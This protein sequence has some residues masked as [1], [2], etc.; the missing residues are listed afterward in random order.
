M[1]VAA[2][3][4]MMSGDA[5]PSRPALTTYSEDEQ[6]LI[7]N[8]AAFGREVLAPKVM[9]MD[10][11]S[12]LD[13]EVLKQLFANGLMGIEI[14]AEY[15]G[16]GMTFTQSCL[17]I[18]EIAKVDPAVAVCVDIQNTLN[19]TIIRKYGSEELKKTWLPKLATD[20]LA[21]F[22]LSEAG[23]GSDAFAMKTTAT[24]KGDNYVINGT[25]MWISNS[26]EAGVFVVFANADPK[27]GYKGITAF[28][29]PRDTKGLVIG[30]K[31]DKLGIRASSTCEVT[32]NDVEV[33]AT[34]VLG[35]V[36]IGYKIAIESL[37][38][39]RIGIAAQMLGLAQGAFNNALPYI[40]QRKQFGQPLANFQGMQ[41]Q[42]ADAATSIESARLLVLN[43][44]RLKDSGQPFMKQ[45]AMAKLVAS[46]VAEDVASN[47]IEWMGGNGF[48]RGFAE[49][50]L[51][52]SKIGSIYEGTSN[53][54]LQTIAKAIQK[55]FQDRKSVV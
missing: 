9:E 46:R 24:K 21:S 43:A 19:N 7:D 8:V 33:P 22:C 55:D 39:G 48:V 37:N 32:F 44:A 20:T 11:T 30:K 25:K 23:S 4:R 17:A 42:Y 6:M 29:V 27:K 14:P 28:V 40:H 50:M 18:E 12:K 5:V 38:E 52:D 10:A 1:G 3:V 35:S 45:A 49:K 51:R 15:G 2:P 53:L 13:P 16:A 26:A 54:Q 36:G 34:N 31:E 47:A 41:F